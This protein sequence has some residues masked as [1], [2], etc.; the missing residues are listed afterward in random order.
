MTKP[1]KPHKCTKIGKGPLLQGAFVNN[2]NTRIASNFKTG[3]GFAL[4]CNFYV[5]T[6]VDFT[7]LKIEVGN[8]KK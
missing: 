2:K 8:V 6:Q 1:Q 4:S 3:T 7:R 5:R